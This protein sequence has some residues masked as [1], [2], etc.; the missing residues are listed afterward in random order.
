MA[1]LPHW[2]A[3]MS[4]ISPIQPPRCGDPSTNSSAFA[5]ANLPIPHPGRSTAHCA[6]KSPGLAALLHAVPPGA[7]AGHEIVVAGDHLNRLAL[8]VLGGLDAQPARLLLLFRR[9]PTPFMT[10]QTWTKLALER[11]PGGVVD[12]LAAPA[13]LD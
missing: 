1:S 3:S 11:L 9:H 10:P 8:T 6:E 13:V 5:K 7:D 4:R 2:R 12:E